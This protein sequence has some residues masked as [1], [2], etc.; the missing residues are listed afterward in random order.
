MENLNDRE[1]RLI[2]YGLIM[3]SDSYME[4]RENA[5]KRGA[6]QKLQDALIDNAI[7]CE[8]LLKKFR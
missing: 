3:L 2:R 6:S 1:K 7:E 4:Q 5:I 8:E